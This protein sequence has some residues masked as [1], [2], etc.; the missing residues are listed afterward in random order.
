MRDNCTIYFY[1]D[2]F[3]SEL[4][5]DPPDE[6]EL[7]N[8]TFKYLDPL[9]ESQWTVNKNWATLYHCEVNFEELRS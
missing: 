8:G 4:K 9:L 1:C 5:F 7:S 6:S 3:L 2:Q